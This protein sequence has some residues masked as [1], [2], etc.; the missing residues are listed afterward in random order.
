MFLT[1]YSG[2]MLLLRDGRVGGGGLARHLCY[3]DGEREQNLGIFS[4]RR[5]NDGERSGGV[6]NMRYSYSRLVK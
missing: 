2:M 5:R 1:P 4:T 6:T 3:E